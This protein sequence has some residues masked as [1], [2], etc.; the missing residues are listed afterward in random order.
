MRKVLTVHN[1]SDASQRARAR[2][3]SNLW[4]IKVYWI[5][6]QGVAI[7]LAGAWAMQVRL[8]GGVGGI[9]AAR[10]EVIRHRV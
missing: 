6:V 2:R 7:P 9:H 10:L 3:A 5:R 1:D 4:G 8:S